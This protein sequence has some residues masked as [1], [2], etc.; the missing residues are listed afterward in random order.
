MIA[1]ALR[2][3]LSGLIVAAVALI[4]RRSPAAGALVASLPLVSLLGMIWLW[5][6]TGDAVRLATH[7]EATFWYV[8]PSLPMFLIV[9]ALLRHGIGFW[10]ALVAGCG[11]TIL[12]YLAIIPVA[13]RFG[14]T[15]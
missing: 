7:A 9:P 14:V 10:W 1:F 12:L 2:T 5:R 11:V 15:L 4:A 3:A 6:D 13:A 8:L